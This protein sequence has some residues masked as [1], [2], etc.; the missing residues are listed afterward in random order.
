MT[1]KLFR[2][3]QSHS[4]KD[5]GR[6]APSGMNQ[7]VFSHRLREYRQVEALGH[8]LPVEQAVRLLAARSAAARRYRPCY[9]CALA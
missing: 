5:L 4:V 9:F 8:K 3:S 6:S 2:V 1:F 7:D